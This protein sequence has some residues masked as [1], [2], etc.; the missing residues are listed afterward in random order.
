MT[1]RYEGGVGDEGFVVYIPT[2]TITVIILLY[3]S[4]FFATCSLFEKIM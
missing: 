2:Q 1:S 3:I 4:F